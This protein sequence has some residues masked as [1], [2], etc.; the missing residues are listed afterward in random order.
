[1]LVL[2]ALSGLLIGCKPG[3]VHFG[4][5]SLLGFENSTIAVKEPDGTVKQVSTKINKKR[6]LMVPS[7]TGSNLTTNKILAEFA[8]DPILSPYH[9]QVQTKRGVVILSGQV[10]NATIRSH[11]VSVARRNDGVLAADTSNL[12]IQKQ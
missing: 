6:V 1:M 3:P 5:S 4:T 12:V 9:I 7:S 11:A 2:A 10:P 8:Q